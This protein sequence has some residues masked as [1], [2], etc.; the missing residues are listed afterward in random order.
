MKRHNLNNLYSFYLLARTCKFKLKLLFFV[1]ELFFYTGEEVC[2]VIMCADRGRNQ[3]CPCHCSV[4]FFTFIFYIWISSVWKPGH[5]SQLQ[6]LAPPSP[7]PKI[8]TI[9]T[10]SSVSQSKK[11]SHLQQSLNQT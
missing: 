1:N 11:C 9:N 3:H 7:P 2:F 10:P 8:R 5:D 4:N 6:P